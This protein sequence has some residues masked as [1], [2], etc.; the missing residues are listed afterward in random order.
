M[1][2]AAHLYGA[3]LLNRAPAGIELSTMTHAVEASPENPYLCM[4]LNVDAR[5]LAALIV[6]TGGA[7][8]PL[9]AST[10]R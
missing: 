1:R 4:T 2:K 3:S 5:E 8:S 10:R 7:S 9:V 6:E